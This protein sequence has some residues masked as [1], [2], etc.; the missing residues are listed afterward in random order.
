M[1]D[2]IRSAA[3]W[4]I[5]DLHAAAETGPWDVVLWRN[6][7]IYTEPAVAERIYRQIA[8]TMSDGGILVVGKA[9]RPPSGLGLV[10]AGPCLYRREGGWSGS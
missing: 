10:S 4:R 5:A 9:E 1:V 8:A 7:A 2:R 3:F 6:A